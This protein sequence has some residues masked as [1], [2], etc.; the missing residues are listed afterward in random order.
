M[1]TQHKNTILA[2]EPGRR[3]CNSLPVRRLV[4][5]KKVHVW[6][7]YHICIFVCS[8]AYMNNN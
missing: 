5:N 7:V 3:G 8:H 4:H 1:K 6:T 2:T